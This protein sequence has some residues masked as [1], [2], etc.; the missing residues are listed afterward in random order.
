MPKQQDRC[1]FCNRSKK[2]VQNNLLSPT[3][4]EDED[5]LLVTQAP[6]AICFDCVRHC[7]Q[8]IGQLLNKR[9]TPRQRQQAIPTVS[10]FYDH[11]NRFVVGQ[12]DAK[13][14]VSIAVRNHYKRLLDEAEGTVKTPIIRDPRLAKVKIEKSNVL[15][16]GPTG[17]GKTL[18]IR[19]LAEEAGVPLA[20]GDATVIT[21]AGYVGEDCENLLLKLLHA[22]DF[23]INAA[24]RGIIYID[25]IDKI[26]KTGGNV[27]ITR[28]VGGEGVQQSLLKMIEGTIANV[29]PQG[30]RKHPEQQFI[31]IDTTNILF[32]CGGSFVGLSDIIRRRINKKTI[33]FGGTA[34]QEDEGDIL[35]QVQP[36]DLIEFGM[37][38]EFIGRLPIV[39]TLNDFSVEDLVKVLDE[40]EDSILLQYRKLCLYDDVDLEFT[41]AAKH[42]IAVQAKAKKIGA[43][44]LRAVCDR[45]MKSIMFNLPQYKGRIVI[46]DEGVVKGTK[47]PDTRK[48]T[49]Q[50][51]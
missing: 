33:G 3:P 4:E 14:Q 18:M 22:A 42:E 7:N 41:E 34:S 45:F 46:I 50:A 17:T 23:D 11:L 29:P 32:I 51:A 30:G 44:A 47:T 20:I 5:G 9:R 36:E 13:Q 15:L 28:D 27:S 31:Q 21:E 2:E 40:P 26:R 1:S 39:A 35:A 12:D 25:E 24:K 43:R 19:K 8:M 38:P 49:G 10:Q 37:I 6:V 48:A 16:I